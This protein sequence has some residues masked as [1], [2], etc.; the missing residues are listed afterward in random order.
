MTPGGANPVVHLEL[1]THNL[2]RACAF[3][4]SLF[5]WRT[6][7]VRTASGSY[8]TL[9]LLEGIGAGIVERDVDPAFWLPYVEVADVREATDLALQLGASPVMDPREG[10]AGW[11][12]VLVAPAGGPIAM[13]QGKPSAG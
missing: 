1:Q 5:R 7:N 3:Y 12:S 8:L 2:S 10:P 11:R 13:W 4:T 9:D 6:E